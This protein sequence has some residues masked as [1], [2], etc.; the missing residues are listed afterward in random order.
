M[1]H[2]PSR[3]FLLI[4]SFEL[5]PSIL[6]FA[7][8]FPKATSLGG[9]WTHVWKV[10]VSFRSVLFSEISLGLLLILL[11][12][13]SGAFCLSPLESIFCFSESIEGFFRL[14]HLTLVVSGRC[15]LRL[16]CLRFRLEVACGPSRRRKWGR[17]VGF[18]VGL[19]PGWQRFDSFFLVTVPTLVYVWPLWILFSNF[20]LR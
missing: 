8:G 7:K 17:L 4:F 9:L 12:Y 3:G 2:V 5:F 16:R 13:A 18:S 14:G 20:I 1:F 6:F 10:D 15:L 19:F 11:G